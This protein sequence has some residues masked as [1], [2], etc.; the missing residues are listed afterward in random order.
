MPDTTI[1]ANWLHHLYAG[2]DDGWLTLFAV[3]RTTGDKVTRWAKVTDID[4]LADHAL[5]L[6]ETSCVWFGVATRTA[7]LGGRRGGGAGCAQI[8]ALWVDIDVESSVHAAGGLPPTIAAAHEILDD[9]PLPPTA[10]VNSGHGLQAWWMLTEPLHAAD[11]TS[12]LADWGTTWA[13]LGRRRGWHIDNVFD[14]AR[15][16]RLPGTYNRK[17]DPVPVVVLEVDWARTYG[18]DDIAQHTLDAPEPDPAIIQRRNVP[19]IG[20]ERPGDAYNATADPR[21]ILERAG[22][23]RDKTDHE[24]NTH[25]RAPHR[26]G[27]NET[28]GATV[29]A[30]GHTTIWSETFARQHDMEV[31]RPYDPFGLTTHIEHGGDWAAATSTLRASGYG[32]PATSDIDAYLNEIDAMNDGED[33]DEVMEFDHGW[34]ISDMAAVMSSD[35]SPPEPTLLRRNDGAHLFYPARLNAL[36]GE[37]GSGKSWLAIVTCA[38]Q[39]AAGHTV[40]YIDYEATAAEL[41]ARL[42]ALGVSPAALSAQFVHLAPEQK[43]NPLAA[44]YVAKLIEELEPTLAVIDSTGESM[45]ADGAKPNDDDD[46]ARWH[47]ELPRFLTRREVTVVLIDHVPKNTDGNTLSAIGSQRKRAAIT[48]AAFMVEVGVSPAKGKEG[49]LRLVCAKDRHGT[50]PRGAL[51]ADVDVLSN[52]AGDDVKIAVRRHENVERPTVLMEKVSRFVEQV[53]PISRRTVEKEVPGKGAGIRKAIECLVVEDWI[54]MV[55]RPGRGGGF[56]LVSLKPYRDDEATSWIPDS[57]T[58]PQSEEEVRPSA[59]TASHPEGTHFGV[60]SDETASTASRPPVQ[61]GRTGT[62]FGDSDTPRQNPDEA[63][64]VPDT[65]TGGSWL[66]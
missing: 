9:F 27:K 56:D 63:N 37:S 59:E 17:A 13:E 30:D 14:V 35:Y 15:V 12:I 49:Y 62:R 46:T 55:P 36:W 19:Y 34:H 1:A 53:G 23:H 65:P 8:T 40:L 48:G 45:A 4:G 20:P 57:V 5:E 6:A 3:D 54:D 38:Q 29:Y 2:V 44:G 39:I 31:R 32:S 16:M 66:F 64:R 52:A 50:F 58:Y 43:W 7:N 41:A 51:V 21:Q 60:S 61:G 33:G 11:A 18:T 47:R 10:V 26:P 28:T 24:G 42:V 25:Y 22:F